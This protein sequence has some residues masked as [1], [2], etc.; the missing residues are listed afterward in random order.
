MNKLP[1]SLDFTDREI[2]LAD[3]KRLKVHDAMQHHVSKQKEKIK[4]QAE[5]LHQQLKEIETRE[6]LAIQILKA[7]YSFEPVL[8]K[9]YSLYQ[10]G[11]E[12]ILSLIEPNEWNRI[13]PIGKF[14]AY[15]R[16]LGDATWEKIDD[17]I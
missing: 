13:C 5:L 11:K 16:Q 3:E 12:T 8:L 7:K 17:N 1:E 9:K 15:V 2:A 10:N 14:I 4:E 6:E